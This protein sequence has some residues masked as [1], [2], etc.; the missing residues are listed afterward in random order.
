MKYLIPVIPVTPPGEE[1]T[2]AN[3]Y[4]RSP[5]VYGPFRSEEEAEE[6]ASWLRETKRVGEHDGGF[7]VVEGYLFI[8]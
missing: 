2:W 1:D 4:V 6:A 5:F 7:L 3:C 8:P